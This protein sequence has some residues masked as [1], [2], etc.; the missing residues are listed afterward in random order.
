M[1]RSI[2]ILMAALLL[3]ACGGQ[4]NG[5]DAAAGGGGGG[6][7]STA[8]TLKLKGADRP[9]DKKVTVAVL[10]PDLKE[11]GILIANFAI[12]MSGNSVR[13]APRPKNAGQMMIDFGLAGD[14]KDFNHPLQVGEYTDK[15]KW[16]EIVTDKSNEQVVYHARDADSTIKITISEITDDMVKGRIDFSK[17]DTSLSGPFEAKIISKHL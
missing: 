16:L 12:D 4:K 9:F 2:A 8:F 14:G 7:N 17:K 3:G 6:S 1:K 11:T 13:G 5:N 10:R 15:V